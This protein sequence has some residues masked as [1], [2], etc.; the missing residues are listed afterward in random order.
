[1]TKK[2]TK[3]QIADEILAKYGGPGIGSKPAIPRLLAF[4]RSA[5]GVPA[6]PMPPEQPQVMPEAPTKKRIPFVR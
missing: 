1:M 6:M 4:L 3:D 2:L 5:R